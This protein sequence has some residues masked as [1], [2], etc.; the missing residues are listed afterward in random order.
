MKGTGF[1]IL[2][3]GEEWMNIIDANIS[4]G[5]VYTPTL[6]PCRTPEELIAALDR[7]GVERALVVADAIRGGCP[8]EMNVRS[9][10][11]TASYRR[12]M[13]VWAILPLETGELGT[14]TEFL[15]SMKRYGVRALAAYPSKHRY[16]LDRVGCGDLLDALVECRIPLLLPLEENS[17]GAGGWALAT[18]LLTETPGLR[19]IVLGTGPWGDDRLFRPLLRA[20]PTLFIEISRYELDGGIAA[21][22]G[23]YGAERLVYGSGYPHWAMGGALLTTLHADISE[24]DKGLILGGNIARLLDEVTI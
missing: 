21:L 18:K 3:G 24:A 19:L 2:P 14:R 23:K 10:K 15:D 11:E 6:A 12:L 17:G 22:C 1:L 5:A 16:L 13:P 20:F 4:Y 8:S 7:A 9:A